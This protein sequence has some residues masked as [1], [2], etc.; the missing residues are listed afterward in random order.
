[1]TAST[2]RSPAPAA[3]IAT[4]FLVSA[5]LWTAVNLL[6]LSNVLDPLPDGVGAAFAPLFL[7]GALA[8]GSGLVGTLRDRVHAAGG[9]DLP[10]IPRTPVRRVADPD[11]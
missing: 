7:I 1:M 6:V 4:A 8:A 3:R 11:D 10:D 2:A 5:G 9:V